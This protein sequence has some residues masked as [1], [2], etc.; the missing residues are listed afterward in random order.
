MCGT[1]SADSGSV[2][3]CWRNPL[4]QPV[5]GLIGCA[6]QDIGVY[7]DLT[8]RQNLACF[9]A[10]EGLSRSVARERAEEVM[11]LLGL[12]GQAKQSARSLSGGQ[13]R[14]LHAGMAIMHE[15]RVVFMDEPTVGADVEA[16]SKLLSIVR[17]LA[18][19]GAAVVY[20][21][22]YLAEFEEL[23]ADIAV[24]DEGR[25]VAHASLEQIIREYA[26]ASIVVTFAQDAPEIDG[27]KRR[28]RDLECVSE[29]AD[30]GHVIAALLSN[31]AIGRLR[32]EDIRIEK[33]D[34]QSAYLAIV[35]NEVRNAAQTI[36][37][38]G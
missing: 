32:I 7:P 15:Q 36:R 4:K 24:L 26:K 19:R 33:A 37:R 21:S 20:T 22:H 18:D 9:G 1:L 30:P 25:I 27:W 3:V 14:R 23:G 16:R 2:S 28:G 13:R 10:I 29:S 5:G 11:E 8:V 17:V 12:T 6:P 35:G 31:P 38:S 34:L